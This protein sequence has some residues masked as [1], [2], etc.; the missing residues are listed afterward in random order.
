MDYCAN[1]TSGP[2]EEGIL[3]K[4]SIATTKDAPFPRTTGEDHL[5]DKEEGIDSNT[6]PQMPLPP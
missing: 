5:E 6:I 4:G 3:I 2:K 1:E